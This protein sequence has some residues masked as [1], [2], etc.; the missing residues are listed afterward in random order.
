MSSRIQRKTFTLQAQAIDE[1]S[2]WVGEQAVSCRTT[3]QSRM[4]VCLLVETI[5]LRMRDHLGEDACV[6]ATVDGRLRHLHRPHLRIEVEGDSFN[7]LGDTES[8]LGAWESILSAAAG[9]LPRYDYQLGRNILTLQIPRPGTNAVL[10]IAS[11][12]AVGVVLGLFGAAIIPDAIR[13]ILASSLLVPLYETWVRIL[14][15]LS[16]PVVFLTVVTTMINAQGI[17]RRGGNS[18]AVITR[19]FVISIL[20]VL[21]VL[22]WVYLFRPLGFADALINEKILQSLEDAVSKVIPSNVFEPFVESNTP[23]LLF[24]AFVLGYVLIKL[25]NKAMGIKGLIREANMVGLQLAGWTSEL[26]PYFVGAFLCFQLWK[27]DTSVLKDIWQPLLLALAV[28]VGILVVTILRW[29]HGAKVP[30]L[31]LVQKLW[32][33]FQLALSTGSLDKSYDHAFTCCTRLL[34]I[35]KTYAKEALPQGL[36]LYMPISAVGTMAF[37]LHTAWTFGLQADVMWCMLAAVMVVVVFVATPPVPGANLL[38]YV[39]LFSTLGIPESVL[40]DAMTFDIVFGIVA[41]AMNQTLLQLELVYQAQ[42]LGLL[43]QDCL[44]RPVT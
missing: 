33:T 3:K 25:G 20:D 36:V 7:P 2:E 37:T 39:V 40:I 13:Q 31:C 12:I 11:S 19:Y 29:A 23:Q 38:A 10:L 41:G 30:F 22:A 21:I 44:R 34:G 27:G 28:S 14:N 35:D 43:D 5:M 32:P 1:L 9:I 15:A 4:R 8:E 24:L 18:L 26:V 42:R 16:G 17:V 6:T